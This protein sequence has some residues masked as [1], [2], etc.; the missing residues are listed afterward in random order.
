MIVFNAEQIRRPAPELEAHVLSCRF[1]MSCS[2]LIRSVQG[3]CGVDSEDY[4]KSEPRCQ[5]YA[6]S[7]SAPCEPLYAPRLH[8]LELVVP[9]GIESSVNSVALCLHAPEHVQGPLLSKANAPHK[10][11]LLCHA[12]CPRQ[13]QSIMVL[14]LSSRLGSVNR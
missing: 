9:H 14:E 5:A 2:R 3:R 8:N 4:Y 10:P 6:P 11:G 1:S 12:L 7:P 13:H